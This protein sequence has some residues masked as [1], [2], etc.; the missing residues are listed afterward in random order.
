MDSPVRI[1]GA[2]AS[3]DLARLRV[4]VA[5]RG[6]AALRALEQHLAHPRYR[7][8]WTRIAERDG[9]IV[10]YALIDHRRLRLGAATLETGRIAAIDAAPAQN[11]PDLLAALL[12]DCLRMLIEEGLP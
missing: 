4:W 6:A 9:Q 12:G 3:D 1:S 2:E 5:A 11:D 7:P 10:G 8:A